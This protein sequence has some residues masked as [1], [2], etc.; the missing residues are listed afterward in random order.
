MKSQYTRSYITSDVSRPRVAILAPYVSYPTF[1][2]ASSRKGGVERYVTELA[3]QL[4]A[5]GF[6]TTLIAPL[7]GDKGAKSTDL[8][9]Y[10][11]RTGMFFSTPVFN[12]LHLAKAVRGFDLLHTQGTFPLIS[13]LNP[14]LAKLQGAPSVITYHFEPSPPGSFGDGIAR[15]YAATLA[16]I[17]RRHDRI[18]FSSRSYRDSASL[19]EREQNEELEDRIR[20]VPMGVDTDFFVPDA[21][22]PVEDRF[23]FVGRFVPYKD[24][25]LL[26]RAM[27]IVN[28][29]LPDHE[30]CA[31]GTGP[32]ESEIKAMAKKLDINVVFKGKVGDEE[33]R[34]LYQS[35]IATVLASHDHQ[36]AFG[37]VLAESMSCGTPVIAAD[38]PGVGDVAS[39]GGTV[40][41]PRSEQALAEAMI[42]AAEGKTSPSQRQG[43]HEKIEN[44]YSWKKVA[45]RTAEVY[46]ELI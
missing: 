6:R 20:Y 32:L 13:D 26:M 11:P 15:A 35:A 16:K 30:L 18:I 29:E 4:S 22:V 1:G 9:T 46:R 42:A 34:R 27:A 41:Q 14:I 2:D 23:L 21:S 33:L 38:I 40:V 3:R 7:D 12:P 31:V 39:V 44:T 36:E 10:I 19:F 37:M 45:E 8:V 28:K 24:L 25:P 5:L 43:L 17:I